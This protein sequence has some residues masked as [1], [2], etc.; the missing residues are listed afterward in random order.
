M[1]L[2]IMMMMMMTMPSTAADCNDQ[3]GVCSCTPSASAAFSAVASMVTDNAEDSA[4]DDESREYCRHV[5]QTPW[6]RVSILQSE[7]PGEEGWNAPTIDEIPNT[8]IPTHEPLVCPA[9]T[10]TYMDWIRSK[11]GQ[12][13]LD[14]EKTIDEAVEWDGQKLANLARALNANFIAAIAGWMPN[15]DQEAAGE[16]LPSVD[17]DV[18]IYATDVAGLQLSL[19]FGAQFEND[20]MK[21]K[22][23]FPNSGEH[24]Y[25]SDL[26]LVHGPFG[27]ENQQQR[28]RKTRFCGT[29][30]YDCESNSKCAKAPQR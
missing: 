14:V 16:V 8:N 24:R 22:E 17:T 2:M 28:K 13:G 18:D 27:V 26:S 3:D 29:T 12:L 7:F 25:T 30:E 21:V 15:P 4:P 20:R 1:W 19:T 11:I 6:S 10:S 9:G 5:S 23:K